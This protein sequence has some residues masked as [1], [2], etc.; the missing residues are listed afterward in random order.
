MQ[1]W[2]RAAAFEGEAKKSAGIVI[3]CWEHFEQDGRVEV[4]PNPAGPASYIPM[5]NP[6]V[7]DN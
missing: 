6:E 1:Q 7:G 5:V 2:C 3:C 4:D